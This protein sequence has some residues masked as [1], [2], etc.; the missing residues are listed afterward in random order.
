MSAKINFD[1]ALAKKIGAN[2]TPTFFVNGER[3]DNGQNIDDLSANLD[4]A[5]RAAIVANGGTVSDDT[6]E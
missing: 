5:V 4:E 1:L 2:A 6:N 3:I